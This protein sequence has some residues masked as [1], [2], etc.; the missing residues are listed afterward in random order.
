VRGITLAQSV[1]V[2]IIGIVGGG[3]AIYTQWP[4]KTTESVA[5]AATVKP[6]LTLEQF[7][8]SSCL[9]P[10]GCGNYTPELLKMRVVSVAAN[11]SQIVGYEGKQLLVTWRMEETDGGAP[12]GRMK[13]RFFKATLNSD[14]QDL[15]PQWL[16][17]PQQE[18]RFYVEVTLY[19]PK[20]GRKIVA[21]CTP[22]FDVS[23]RQPSGPLKGSGGQ[24]QPH[25]CT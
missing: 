17:L 16:P 11:V 13:Q 12:V 18:G 14:Q 20:T 22:D 19:Y 25:S 3:L 8:E 24:G 6:G 2:A 23:R 15:Q 21:T 7:I 5:L 9:T 4:H 10:T 1:V